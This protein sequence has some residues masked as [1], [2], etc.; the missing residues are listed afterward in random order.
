MMNFETIGG[1]IIEMH[2]RFA[3]QWCDLYG[4]WFLPAVID[5]YAFKFWPQTVPKLKPAFSVIL[6]GEHKFYKYPQ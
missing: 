5:L 1:H 2:L 4:D 6:F 3:D